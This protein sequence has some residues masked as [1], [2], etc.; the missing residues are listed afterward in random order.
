[1]LLL[2]STLLLL[3]I[4]PLY[5]TLPFFS[6]P[7]H[8]HSCPYHFWFTFSSTHLCST[9]FIVARC[10]WYGFCFSSIFFCF[11]WFSNF[12]HFMFV[13]NA[14]ASVIWLCNWISTPRDSHHFPSLRI[15]SPLVYK[16]YVL[17]TFEMLYLYDWNVC[18]Y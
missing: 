11:H 14:F 7:P 12:I 5:S 17:T 10:H 16:R 18:L 13:F 9:I 2:A 15:V 3:F 6:S 4:L 8:C 1:V